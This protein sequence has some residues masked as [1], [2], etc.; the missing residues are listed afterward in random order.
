MSNTYNLQ[1][2]SSNSFNEPFFQSIYAA[3]FSRAYRLQPRLVRFISIVSF[4][5][6]NDKSISARSLVIGSRDDNHN[7][8]RYYNV[9]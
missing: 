5:G 7:I 1:N 2:V 8:K 9:M 6:Q 3:T 4:I